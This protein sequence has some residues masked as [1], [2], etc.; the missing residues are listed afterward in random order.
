MVSESDIKSVRNRL[1]LSPIT[2]GTVAYDVD[3]VSLQR[4]SRAIAEFSNLTMSVQN[5]SISWITA[6]NSVVL[7]TQL[8][9]S[10]V[11]ASIDTE[12]AKRADRLFYFSGSLIM[13]LPNVNQADIADNLWPT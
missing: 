4:M 3:A 9:L 13:Q 2:I 7:L 8:E 6:D 11:K 5:G 12:I 10:A 1:E